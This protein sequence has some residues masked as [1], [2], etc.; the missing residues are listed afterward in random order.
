MPLIDVDMNTNHDQD[1]AALPEEASHP[2]GRL[3]RLQVTYSIL[4]ADA[5]LDM[6]ERTYEL[7]SPLTC[8]LLLP[9]MNDTYLLTGKD[10]RY[11]VRVYRA[12]WRSANE[13]AYELDLLTHLVAKGMSVSAPIAAIDRRLCRPLTAP[14]GIRYVALFTYAEGE[15]LTWTNAD[16]CRAAGRLLG[17]IHSAT[18]D[19]VTSHDRGA[20]DI[21]HLIHTPL[22]AIE[23]FLTHRPDDWTYLVALTAKL[24]AQLEAVHEMLD[25]GPCH[26]DFG[27]GNLFVAAD[28]RLTAFD[29]DLCGPGWRA[30]DLAA[31]QSVANPR[32]DGSIWSAFAE[33]Y[34]EVRTLNESD[35][36]AVTLFDPIRHLWRMGLQAG[37]ASD[38]GISRLK[39]T[40]LDNELRF[41]RTWEADHMGHN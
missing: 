36:S 20:L 22:V 13:I 41:F 34:G 16:Q 5:L 17:A 19:F 9:S 38:W 24:R 2:A 27:G 32:K 14:E 18:D 30:C 28:C 3:S 8:E 31:I 6:I 10:C 15:P 7:P 12:S 21:E 26:G 33:G 11:I 37:N 23:P 29:F 35:R 4:S 1:T 40:V 25:W 39:D